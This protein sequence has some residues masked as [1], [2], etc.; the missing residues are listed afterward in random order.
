MMKAKIDFIDSGTVTSPRGFLAGATY[1]RIKAGAE[2]KGERPLDLGILFSEVP[3]VASGLFTTNRIKAAPVVL[4]QEKIQGG[5]ARA[6]VVNSGCANAC[7]GEP[8]MLAAQE[9]ASLAARKLR[10]SPEEAMVASTGVICV[11]LPMD[12]IRAGLQKMTLSREGGHDLARAIMTTDRVP[13]ETAVRARIGDNE[14]TI[15]GITK[16]SGMIHPNLGTMLCF[17]TTDAA[18]E[19]GFLKRALKQAADISFNMIS[20]DGDTSTNDTVILMAN[21]RA[22]NKPISM[23][24]EQGKA[25]TE[26]LKQ[27]CIALAKKMAADGEGAS[28]LIEV[29]VKGAPSTKD[30]RRVARTVVSSSL[31]KTAV[32][33][34]DPNWG[35]VIAAAGRS[36]VAIVESKTD[37][38]IGG[39]PLLKNGQPL[40]FD[41]KALVEILKRK[42]VPIRLNLNLGKGEATAWGCDMTEEYVVANSAY[43]T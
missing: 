10:V 11:Q 4:C 26:A 36:G 35:R 28:K 6:V 42:E 43:T 32:Y 30:A 31:V 1:A 37:L 33:G 21:G 9:M 7:T 8:G 41:D 17:L 3:C 39:V 12:K 2:K 20:V 18:V 40:P 23:A 13:K 22:G 16:G 15:G 27:V 38:E 24:N 14:F 25:F 29:D 5:R 34:N 19:L